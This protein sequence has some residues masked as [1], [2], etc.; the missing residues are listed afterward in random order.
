MEYKARVASEKMII[1][2]ITGQGSFCQVDESRCQEYFPLLF[3]PVKKVPLK[4]S[5]AS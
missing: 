4:K 3:R 2:A 5:R 1:L